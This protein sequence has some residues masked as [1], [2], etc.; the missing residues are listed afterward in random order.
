MQYADCYVQKIK[1]EILDKTGKERT[2]EY[3]SFLALG[4]FYPMLPGKTS[5]FSPDNVAN[6][7]YVSVVYSSRVEVAIFLLIPEFMDA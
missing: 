5:P 6:S 3:T 1:E 2:S 4:G 7:V